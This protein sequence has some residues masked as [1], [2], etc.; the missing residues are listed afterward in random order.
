MLDLIRRIAK[1]GS[2]E[3]G[4]DPADWYRQ[5][6]S[7]EPDYGILLGRIDSPF[8]APGSTILATT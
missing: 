1:A 6:Y 8:T 5:T 3:A 7:E 4:D 2:S